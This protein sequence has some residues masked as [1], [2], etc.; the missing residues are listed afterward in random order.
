MKVEVEYRR[1]KRG[2]WTGTIRGEV[3]F[4]PAYE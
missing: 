4:V 1:N 3:W 2:T